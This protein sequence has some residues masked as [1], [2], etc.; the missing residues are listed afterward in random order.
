MGLGVV[1]L[2]V[3]GLDVP[4]TPGGDDLHAGGDVLDR[5]LEADLV[6]AL[7]GA[8]VGDGV[9]AFL[10]R[11]LHQTLG[12]DGTGKGR[13]QQVVL[14]FRARLHAGDDHVVDHLV[15]KVKGVELARAGF[16]G[17]FLETVQ[18]TH[19]T[20]VAGHGDD[21]GIVVVLLQP[22]NDNGCIQ[23]AGIGE[24]DFF[25]FIFIHF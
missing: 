14:I 20:D 15:G 9:G 2:L 24:H 3:A 5:Q 17:F 18:L 16:E 1:D 8:A 25:N 23:A 13:T 19:L 21:L 4:L 7:A 22:G 6:V 11:D 10:Q 12:D